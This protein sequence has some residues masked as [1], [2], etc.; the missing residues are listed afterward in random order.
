MTIALRGA[1]TYTQASGGGP[2]N[3]P[4]PSSVSAGDVL[5]LCASLQTPTGV[6]SITAPSGWTLVGDLKAN[7]STPDIAMYI[8]VAAGTEGGTNLSV[9][10]TSSTPA[11]AAQIL[12]FSGVD[13]TTPQDVA[14]TTVDGAALTTCTIPGQTIVTAGA[15]QVAISANNTT[16]ST[17]TPPTGFTETGDQTGTVRSFEVSYIL[18]LSAGA[19]GS[20]VVTWSAS[21]RTVGIL[22]ALRP[23]SVSSGGGMYL[24]TAGGILKAVNITPL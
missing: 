8:K 23:G 2:T 7:A 22:L 12:A 1:G 20:R 4:Y 19:T 11:F 5:V 9:A 10:Y 14:A 18:G 21:A 3:V 16:N 17:A 13:N 24:I 6:G 15:A